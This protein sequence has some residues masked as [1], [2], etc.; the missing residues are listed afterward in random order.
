MV[1]PVC[2]GII[3]DTRTT[4]ECLHR[5]CSECITKAL[6]LGKKECPKCRARCPSHRSL[7]P[8]PKFDCLIALLLPKRE[9][10]ELNAESLMA[11]FSS[12]QQV[13]RR[14]M[15]DGM[16][17][18]DGARSRKRLKTTTEADDDDLAAGGKITVMLE[19]DKAE[20]GL[21]ALPHRFCVVPAQCSGRELLRTTWVLLRLAAEPNVPMSQAVRESAHLSPALRLRLRA[22]A[23]DLLP[24]DRVEDLFKASGSESTLTL[25][26]SMRAA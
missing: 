12:S 11:L 2:L 21:P 1:C 9:N 3:V 16:R 26:Y 10:Y 8:D 7:R 19:R 14:S 5:F 15:S 18:Q 24:G 17:L 25:H 20:R 23:R 4:M 22:G 13:M 6:R